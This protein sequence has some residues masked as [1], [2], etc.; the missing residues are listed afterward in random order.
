M[1]EFIPRP[2][3]VLVR[4]EGVKVLKLNVTNEQARRLV[5]GV[6]W[7]RERWLHTEGCRLSDESVVDIFIAALHHEVGA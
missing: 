6:R 3:Q 5:R 7:A 1:S 2:A 4:L